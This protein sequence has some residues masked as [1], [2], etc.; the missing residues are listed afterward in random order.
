MN[1]ELAAAI[2]KMY[3]CRVKSLKPKRTVWLCETD[4]GTWVVKGYSDFQK[5][6]WV[7]YLSRTLHDRGFLDVVRYLPTIQGVP[8]FKWN[9]TYMTVMERMPGREGSYFHKS[10]VMLSLRKLAEFHKYSVRIPQGPPPEEGI[11]LIV[12]WEKRYES[13]LCIQQEIES[14][15]IKPS[16]LTYLVQRNAPT[17][18]KEAKYTLDVARCSGLAAEYTS[19]LYRQHIAHKDLA[20]H[21]FLI[22]AFRQS[23]IDL[24]TAAYDTPLVDI[25]QLISRALVLQRWDL[26]VF[27]EAIETYRQILPL[28]EAQVALIFL[29]LRFPDN[30]IREVT[31]VFEKRKNFQ[32]NQVEYYLR[33]IMKN[34]Q[35]R[36]RFFAGYEN[37]IYNNYV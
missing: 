4:R 37:F 5:A 25:V 18:L 3:R 22:S 9:N 19:A 10:D 14:G 29:L 2:E 33:I 35:H 30:F 34:W 7:T 28:S 21:N 1:Q 16:R 17:I 8:V 36:E 6:A 12:K 27:T 11:P 31:G 26:N 13:F 24:D 15:R 23:I 20:S 32:E